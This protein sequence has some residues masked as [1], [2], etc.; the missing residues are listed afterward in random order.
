[1]IE[2]ACHTWAFNDL[3]LP[4]AL[5]TIAE[6]RQEPPGCR[7]VVREAKIA[8]ETAVADSISVNGCCLTAVAFS[9]DRVEFDLLAES[10]R[11]T[12]IAGVGLGGKVNL[13]RALLPTTRALLPSRIWLRRFAGYPGSSGR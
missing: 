9:E 4:E 6:I 5:G 7:L 1:M 10:V 12:S 13:E 8:A 2:F 3:T 11:L